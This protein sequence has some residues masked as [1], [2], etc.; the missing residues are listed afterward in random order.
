MRL[1][2]LHPSYLDVK[3]LCG[4]WREALLAQKV[5]RGET[6]GYRSHPQ[7]VRFKEHPHPLDAISNYLQSVYEEGVSRGY[8]FNPE[9]IG[10][11]RRSGSNFRNPRAAPL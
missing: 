3:G 10:A 6:I 11:D 8:R 7:L 1:W 2:T 5:L 9:K 4:L